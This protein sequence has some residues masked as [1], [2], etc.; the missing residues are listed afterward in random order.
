[1]GRDVEPDIIWM[2]K[3]LG[4]GYPVAAAIAREDVAAAMQPGT[5]GTT[6]GGN[7]V[8][9]AA[10]L[11]TLEIIEADGL[12]EK[13]AAQLPTLQALADARPLPVPFEIRGVG[14]MI[15]VGIGIRGEARRAPQGTCP[16][17]ACS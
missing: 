3:A 6:F 7:P 9:C 13:A 17:S 12:Y 15:G 2:A 14:A 16:S 4:G 5:H 10:G 11:A 8:A 1:M